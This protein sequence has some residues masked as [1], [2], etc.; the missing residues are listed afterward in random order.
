M[1]PPVAMLMSRVVAVGILTVMGAV[2]LRLVN[3][4]LDGSHRAPFHT[5]VLP[6]VGSAAVVLVHLVPSHINN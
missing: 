6:V 1:I 4:L 5:N 2:P 3:R